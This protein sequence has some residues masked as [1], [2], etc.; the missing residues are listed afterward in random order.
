MLVQ[1]LTKWKIFII[2]IHHQKDLNPFNY[3]TLC[4]LIVVIENILTTKEIG[5]N[6]W[7]FVIQILFQKLAQ[8]LYIPIHKNFTLPICPRQWTSHHKEQQLY[9]KG[10]LGLQRKNIENWIILTNLETKQF[11]KVNL[12]HLSFHEKMH[13]FFIIHHLVPTICV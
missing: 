12:S 2:C 10:H 5:P 1:A 9:R 11:R 4:I 13:S 7:A 3:W 8:K 6:T